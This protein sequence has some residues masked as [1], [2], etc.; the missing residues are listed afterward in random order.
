MISLDR[1]ACNDGLICQA[2][3]PNYVFGLKAGPRGTQRLD[4]TYPDQCCECW[5]CVAACPRA[6]LAAYA[7]TSSNGQTEGFLVIR[8][9]EFL[10]ELE[11]SLGLGTCCAGPQAARH[12]LALSG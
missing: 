11:A 3:C 2:I 9:G 5:Q 8:A 1:K 7:G 10:S 4:L 12:P 6:A